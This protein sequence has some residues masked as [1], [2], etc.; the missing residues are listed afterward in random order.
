MDTLALPPR[1]ADAGDWHG[2]R[3][4]VQSVLASVRRADAEVRDVRTLA[5]ANERRH[6]NIA[7]LNA[8]TRDT[9]ARAVSRRSRGPVI[10]GG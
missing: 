8:D 1:V 4:W 3:V 5:L 7:L 9:L 2:S 6:G 10:D